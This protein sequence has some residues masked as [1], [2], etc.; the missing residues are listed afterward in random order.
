MRDRSPYRG[1]MLWHPASSVIPGEASTGA[2][3]PCTPGIH[4]DSIRALMSLALLLCGLRRRLG[5]RVAGE[6]LFAADKAVLIGVP[7]REPP[8]RLGGNAALAEL[9]L[10]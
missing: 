7:Q 8:L 5:K 9:R 10:G 2:W 6:E 3:L 1:R 4:R